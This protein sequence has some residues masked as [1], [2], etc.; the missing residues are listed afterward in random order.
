MRITIADIQQNLGINQTYDIVNAIRNSNPIVAQYIPLA[1]AENVA[2]IG[3]GLMLNQTVQNEFVTSLVDRIGLVVIKKASLVNPLKKFKKGAM[4]QGRTIE[5]IFVDIT[6][7]KKYDPEEA[8]QTVFQR[9]LPHVKTLFHERN[10]QSFYH[11]TIQD[12]SLKTAFTSWSNFEGFIAGIINAIY[13]SAEVDEYKYMKMILDVYYANGH[14]KVVPVLKPDTETAT[15]ELIKSIR[16]YAQEMSLPFGSRDYNSLAVHTRSEIDDL[17]L[18]ITAKLNA[19]VDVDVLAKAFN[20]DRTTFLGNVTVVDKFAGE[21]IEALLVDKDLFM[22]YDN[23]LSLETIRNP[24]GKYW[25]YYYHV[26]QTHSASRFSNAIAF[27]SGD[28]KEV[29]SVIVDPTIMSLK[30]GKSFEFTAYVRQTVEG[31]FPVVWSVE[32]FEGS[33]VAGGTTIDQNGKLTVG[34]TQTGTV[35]VLA[36]VS[37][38]PDGVATNGD[39]YTVVGESIVTVVPTI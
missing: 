35:K 27:V 22:V 33:T 30:Q 17:H 38:N 24:R 16:Q 20:M 12:S 14:F 7:E 32:G 6:K 39:E 11:Q 25:N 18:F 31:D 26:W 5:E 34:A 8:E 10:R 23:E 19:Q 13:N 1:N 2:E 37:V 4:P 29:T 28:V 36:T 21:G 3:S 9:E 15:R